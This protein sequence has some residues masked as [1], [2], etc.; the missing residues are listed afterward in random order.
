M[1]E[2]SMLLMLA[3]L[4]FFAPIPGVC[5]EKP[6]LLYGVSMDRQAKTL[7][8]IVR[9]SGCTE[10]SDIAFSLEGD[11]LTFTRSMP[12]SCKA[13]PERFA[14]TYTLK[15]LGIDPKACFRIGNPITLRDYVY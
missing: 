5:A 8:I 14:I 15:E 3:N 4:V 11:T 9:A 6:E 7:T 1:K 13:M 12:D 10:K 2:I